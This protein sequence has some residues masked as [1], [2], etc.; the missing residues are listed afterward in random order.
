MIIVVMFI[1]VTERTKE[2]G[3]LR[4]LGATTG[5]VRNLFLSEALI[6]GGLAGVTGLAVALGMAAGVNGAIASAIHYGIL[7]PSLGLSL[8]IIVLSLVIGV[9]A[10]L[11]PSRQAA[12]LDPIRA[13]A[14][15]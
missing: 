14:A 15:E 2:I 7:Q 9:V 5:D 8:G 11:A 3:V 10:A 4:A 6:I 12:K 1:S 13:L